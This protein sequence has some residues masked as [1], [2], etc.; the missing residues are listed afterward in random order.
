MSDCKA[1]GVSAICLHDTGPRQRMRNHHTH[2]L[3]SQSKYGQRH[4]EDPRTDSS[5]ESNRELSSLPSGI[6]QVS[7][8]QIQPVPD[9]QCRQS[10]IHMLPLDESGMLARQSGSLHIQAGHSIQHFSVDCSKTLGGDLPSGICKNAADAT[11]FATEGQ[12]T[13]LCSCACELDTI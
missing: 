5:T 1:Y 10:Y 6:C 13:G 8:L 2:G 4:D 7:R 11:S 3:D 9:L 12:G